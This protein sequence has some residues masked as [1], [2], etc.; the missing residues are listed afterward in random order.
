MSHIA[1]SPAVSAMSAYAQ[2]SKMIEHTT[3]YDVVRI[4]AKGKRFGERLT[5]IW[6]SENSKIYLFRRKPM[7]FL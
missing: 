1:T 3:A 7:D 2:L 5:L 4:H 6:P